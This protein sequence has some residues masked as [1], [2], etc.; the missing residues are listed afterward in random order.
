MR[1]LLLSVPL[2]ALLAACGSPPTDYTL[3]KTRD[4]LEKT[5]AQIA[6]PKGDFVASTASGG[7]FRAV[8]HGGSNFVTVSFGADDQEAQ[9]VAQGYVRFHGANIGVADIL[10]ESR[11]AVML[12]KLHPSD[13][14]L[15]VVT[16]CLK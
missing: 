12:W 4:C 14:E 9:Q 8:L 7:D 1:K 5:G 11:N 2:V 3:A 10:Y 15:K 6:H 16:D 13:D